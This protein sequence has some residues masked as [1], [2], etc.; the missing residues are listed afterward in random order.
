LFDVLNY[1]TR[2]A[3]I[4]VGAHVQDIV[5]RLESIIA[6]SGDRSRGADAAIGFEESICPHPR[7]GLRKCEAQYERS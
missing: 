5:A 2:R 1:R 4:W 7:P 6:Q 3:V